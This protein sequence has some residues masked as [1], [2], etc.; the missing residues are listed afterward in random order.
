MDYPT[1]HIFPAITS[2]ILDHV[3]RDA[4]SMSYAKV[5]IEENNDKVIKL[6]GIEIA[7]H[8]EWC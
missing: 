2:G 1:I 8:A 4:V 5:V 3:V 6:V 7:N